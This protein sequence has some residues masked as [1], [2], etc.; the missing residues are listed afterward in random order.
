MCGGS[1]P[2]AS[3]PALKISEFCDERWVHDFLKAGNQA[4]NI[5]DWLG[6]VDI[7]VYIHIYIYIHVYI[8]TYTYIHIYTYVYIYIYMYA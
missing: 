3:D 5:N 2:R 1:D 6:E 7:Y 4:A 8:Y